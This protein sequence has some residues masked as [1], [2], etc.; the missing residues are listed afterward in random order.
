MCIFLNLVYFHAHKVV[1]C[2]SHIWF[3]QSIPTHCLKILHKAYWVSTAAS[4]G[5]KCNGTIMEHNNALSLY[6]CSA[7]ATVLYNSQS[8]S[9][10][11]QSH[12]ELCIASHSPLRMPWEDH[13]AIR[14]IL[15]TTKQRESWAGRCYKY[16]GLTP[17]IKWRKKKIGIMRRGRR[18]DFFF[19]DS[20]AVGEDGGGFGEEKNRKLGD[21]L[22][23]TFHVCCVG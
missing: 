8:I 14:D 9:I 10:I 1:L 5:D 23:I 15:Q 13:G 20:M 3:L 21:K 12:Q 22:Q 6:I 2:S 11:T 7:L 4:Q 18:G 16:V 19:W 17:S